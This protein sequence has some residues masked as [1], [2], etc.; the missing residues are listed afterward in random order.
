MTELWLKF[1]DENG[2]IKRILVEPEKFSVGRHSENDLAVPNGKLSRQHIKIDRFGDVFVVSDCDS[3]N[4][5]TI[6]GEDLTEPVGLKNED[7]LNLGGGLEIEIELISDDPNV[8]AHNNNGAGSGENDEKDSASSATAASVS[9]SSGSDSDSMSLLWMIPVFGLFILIF[10]GGLLFVFSGSDEE[11]AKNDGGFIYSTKR[12]S[13]RDEMPKDEE[14]PTPTKTATP[15]NN[16]NNSSSTSTSSTPDAISTPQ[17]SS[18]AEKIGQN[19][20][21]FM[22]HIA[23]N[24][25]KPFLTTPQIESVN[26]KINQLKNSAA[27]AENLKAV[28]KNASQFEAL[29]NSKNLKPQFLAIAALTQIGNKRGDPFAVAQTMLPVLTD[30]KGTLDNKLADDNLL[31]IAGYARKESGGNTPLQNVI[32]GLSKS[33]Q[34]ENITP[35]EIRT[36]WFL[37]KKDKISDA[38]FNFALQFLAIGIISQNPKDFNV[39]ADALAF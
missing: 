13:P 2:E 39:A 21:S 31:I 26:S 9:S 27:L 35:R 15:E 4:G 14:T 30:L 5:T 6:N 24:D 19:A 38:E 33:S 37:K 11:T 36:I 32:E 34:S 8:S 12:D 1:Q 7:K 18:D 17:V 3:S 28:K 25:P 10:A 29:A 23:F 22:R 16:S 20:S